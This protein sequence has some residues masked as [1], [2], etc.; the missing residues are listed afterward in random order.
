VGKLTE[1]PV[2]RSWQQMIMV[3]RTGVRQSGFKIE[4]GEMDG[5]WN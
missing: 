2:G 1:R 3:E 5:T 4:E